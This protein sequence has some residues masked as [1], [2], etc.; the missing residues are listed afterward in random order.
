MPNTKI[1]FNYECSISRKYLIKSWLNWNVHANWLFIYPIVTLQLATRK[2]VTNE[3]FSQQQRATSSGFGSAKNLITLVFFVKT[4]WVATIS[5]ELEKNTT[6]LEGRVMYN[7]YNTK[8]CC[9]CATLKEL[10]FVIDHDSLRLSSNS[11]EW[12]S[13]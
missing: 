6:R 1:L 4:W 3:S 5:I 13:F 10:E 9:Y 2:M 8:A 11:L 12:L 7:I